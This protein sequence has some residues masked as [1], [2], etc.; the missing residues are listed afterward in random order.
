MTRGGGRDLFAKLPDALIRP[1]LGV[2]V[3]YVQET[4]FR[5]SEARQPE[6]LV[7]RV[8]EGP[9]RVIHHGSCASSVNWKSGVNRE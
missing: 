9:L 4:V 1:L 8:D 6:E 5:E 2:L 3:L 7:F